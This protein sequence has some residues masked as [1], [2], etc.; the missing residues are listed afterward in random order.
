MNQE[1]VGVGQSGTFVGVEQTATGQESMQNRQGLQGLGNR[2]EGQ[3]QGRSTTSSSR[4]RAERLR[5][6]TRIAFNYEVVSPTVVQTRIDTQLAEHQFDVAGLS[7]SLDGD[8]VLT[9]SGVASSLD[10]SRLAETYLGFEPG[11]RRVDNQ[12]VVNQ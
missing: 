9:L 12:I 1:F 6:V 4:S 5:P 2:G 7:Y 3:S 11:V 8:G 10:A